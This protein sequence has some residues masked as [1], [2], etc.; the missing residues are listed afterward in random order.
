MV[1]KMVE[2]LYGRCYR[3]VRGFDDNTSSTLLAYVL[4]P[5]ALLSKGMSWIVSRFSSQDK[6]VAAYGTGNLSVHNCT[7][8]RTLTLPV[9]R[10]PFEDIKLPFPV[11]TDA[12]LKALYGNYWQLPPMDKRAIHVENITFD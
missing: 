11:D 12:N 10:L 1:R 4:Y 7:R 9:Q 3:H 5:L 8:L 6:Y 2:P